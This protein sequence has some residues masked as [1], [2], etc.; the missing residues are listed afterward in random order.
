M[1][2]TTIEPV[3]LENRISR[4]PVLVNSF[5]M[6]DRGL[7]RETNEDNFLIGELARTLWVRQSST[8]R[9]ATS[10]GRNRGHVLLVADGVGGH[11]AGEVASALSV[12]SIEAFLLHVL[13]RFSNLSD[14]DEPEVIRE[15]KDA[16]WQADERIFA[17]AIRHPELGGMGTTL[18]LAMIS[19]RK[20]FVLHAG[21]SRCYL[22]RDGDLRQLTRDHT[23]AAE[24]ARCGVIPS[25]SV[26]THRLR[27]VVTNI[28]GGFRIGVKVDVHMEDL[29]DGDCVLLCTDGVTDMLSHEQ[30]I[31]VL[32]SEADPE[33]ACRRLV[34]EA[35]LEG[36]RDNI[37]AIV[38]RI[39]ES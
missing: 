35:R 10:H 31:A 15:L 2:A 36:G 26:R 19:G 33:E 29:E 32:E 24:L 8:T 7:V 30:I 20:L 1:T 5:G 28:L 27:H 18:T 22:L 39:E 9:S 14:A 34:D 23:M 16:L 4:P 38:A 37:T 6:T 17:E 25:G 11:H 21:D 3:G 13:H 12:A